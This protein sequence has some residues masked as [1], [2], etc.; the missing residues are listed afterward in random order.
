MK[1]IKFND[2]SSINENVKNIELN[3]IAKTLADDVIIK[4]GLLASKVD[5]PILYK[6]QYN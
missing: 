2:Y 4:I 1:I 5:S 3:E 6:S